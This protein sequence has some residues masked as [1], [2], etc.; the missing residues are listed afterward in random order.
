MHAQS[1]SINPFEAIVYSDGSQ[2]PK[3]GDASWAC[4]I[5]LYDN[6]LEE[7]HQTLILPPEKNALLYNQSPE[8]QPAKVILLVG[9]QG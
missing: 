9:F 7:N 8:S 2:R 5:I 6:E 1:D 4:H 3:E